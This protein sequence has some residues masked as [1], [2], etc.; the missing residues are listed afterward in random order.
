MKKKLGEELLEVNFGIIF[1]VYCAFMVV[2]AFLNTTSFINEGVLFNTYSGQLTHERIR[3]R[4]ALQ[5]KFEYV[6]YLFIPLIFLIKILFNSMVLSIGLLFSDSRTSF[7]SNFN[8]CLK[9]EYVFVV[10]LLV[11]FLII[12][13]FK[14]VDTLQDLAYIPG[15]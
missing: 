13:F 2:I 14:E 10:M 11:K 1:W 3:E 12:S 7:K 9:A 6:T 4:L 5:E 15:H 8:V